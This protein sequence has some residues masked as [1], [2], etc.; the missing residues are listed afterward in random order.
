MKRQVSIGI[1]AALLLS[2]ALSCTK[3]DSENS[4][5]GDGILVGFSLEVDPATRAIS[6]GSLVDELYY[7]VF[8]GEGNYIG[9]SAAMERTTLPANVSITLSV[10]QTYKIAFW[11]Q[12]SSCSAY[13][14]DYEDPSGEDFDPGTVRITYEDDFGNPTLENNDE[15][16][17]AF[18]A[19]VTLTVSRNTVETVTMK[20]PFAQ[21]NV[22]SPM[23]IGRPG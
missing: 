9:G 10:G 13:S 15:S 7:A 8:D 11:A 19:S 2:S 4:Q 14:I 21:I 5:T 18:F 17:D 20:R 6:D 3:N 16:L 22:G 12:D 1:A 23:R